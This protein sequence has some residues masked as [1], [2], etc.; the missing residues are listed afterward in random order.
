MGSLFYFDTQE[1][2]KDIVC[3]QQVKED[4][5]VI[6]LEAIIACSDYMS[7]LYI[8]EVTTRLDFDDLICNCLAEGNGPL[9]T[10]PCTRLLWELVQYIFVACEIFCWDLVAFEQIKRQPKLRQLPPSLMGYLFIYQN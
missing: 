9:T 4:L 5:K 7:L 6:F 8:C 3:R 10:E 2:I 1:D